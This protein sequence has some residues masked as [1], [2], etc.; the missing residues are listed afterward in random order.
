MEPKKIK[1]FTVSIVS[2]SICHEVMVPTFPGASQDEAGLT[3]KFE[4]SHVGGAT[5]RTPPI[6]RSPVEF[7]ERTRDWTPGHAGKEG[8]QLARTG[9]L[10]SPSAVIVEPK[11]IKSVT[12]SIVSLSVCHEVMGTEAIILGFLNV[13]F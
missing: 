9:A 1:S 13:V 4:T 3:R 11:K 10:Q 7:G 8:P 2:P 12:V 5:C 6:P